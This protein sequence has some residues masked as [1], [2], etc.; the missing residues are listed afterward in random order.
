MNETPTP[1]SHSTEESRKA[2]IKARAGRNRMI[3]LGLVGFAVLLFTITALR[4]MQ[5][6]ADRV[7]G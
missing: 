4:L 6:I 7:P 3:A 2:F 1:V 5:N